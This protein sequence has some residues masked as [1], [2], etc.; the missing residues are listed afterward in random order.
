MRKPERELLQR[1]KKRLGAEKK[2]KTPRRSTIGAF[3][4]WGRLVG[5]VG[6]ILLIGLVAATFFTPL[7]AIEKIEVSGTQRLDQAKVEKSL[8]S[9][10]GRPLPTVTESEVGELLSDF[11]LVDTFALQA[12]P[13]HVIT[14]KIRERQPILIVP[15]AGKNYLYDAAGVKIAESTK[16]D[17]FPYLKS[18]GTPLADERFEVAVEVLLSLP[19]SNYEDIFSIQVSKALTTTMVLRDSDIQVIW[20]GTDQALLK[21]EVLDSLIKTGQKDGVTIDVSSPN[22][23]VVTYPNY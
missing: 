12:Q 3:S 22:S 14:V 11:G 23:P 5:I 19:I 15:L 17:V 10:I 7:L 18:P 21:A 13:P 8:K 9:L 1:E 6:P 20:G 2:T 4:I 16:S